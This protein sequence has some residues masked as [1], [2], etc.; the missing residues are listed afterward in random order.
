MPPGLPNRAFSA[1]G[2]L[3]VLPP[4]REDYGFRGKAAEA[5]TSAGG[6]CR[7]GGIPARQ[8]QTHHP[9]W[10]GR[11]NEQGWRD[12]ALPGPWEAA[13]GAMGTFWRLYSTMKK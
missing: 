9:A 8:G 12:R 7:A 5:Q 4:I 11:E 13:S 6:C 1:L 3:C 10:G 2:C